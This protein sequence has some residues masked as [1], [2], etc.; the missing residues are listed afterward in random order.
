MNFVEPVLHTRIS[1]V[2]SRNYQSKYALYQVAQAIE[3]V[4]F[5]ESSGSG[6]MASDALDDFRKEK[7]LGQLYSSSEPRAKATYRFDYCRKHYEAQSFTIASV[8]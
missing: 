5:D 4:C 1:Y 7:V 3:A 6:I 8:R 2:D